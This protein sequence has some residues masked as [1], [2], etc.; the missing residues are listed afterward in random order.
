MF[1]LGEYMVNSAIQNLKDGALTVTIVVN[2]IGNYY[3]MG[4]ITKEEMDY[5]LVRVAAIVV[6]E[7]DPAE[8]VVEEAVE[9]L[10][11]EAE[12]TAIESE[13]EDITD[14][15]SMTVA[16]LKALAKERGLSGYSSMSKAELI[17]LLEAN[18]SEQA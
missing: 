9:E 18:D 2:Y 11:T 5:A 1:N 14:Y 6:G 8:A 12:E 7:P 3:K 15:N 10:S 17:A 16:E 13:P 4:W